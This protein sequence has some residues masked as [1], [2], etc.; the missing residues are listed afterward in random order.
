LSYTSHVFVFQQPF[1]RTR[2][3][4]RPTD[5]RPRNVF[6]F[7]I[8]PGRNQKRRFN[9]LQNFFPFRENTVT[10]LVRTAIY[11]C[12]SIWSSFAILERICFLFVSFCVGLWEKLRFCVGCSFQ[13]ILALFSCME[14]VCTKRLLSSGMWRR[15]VW[16][17]THVSEEPAS[18]VLNVEASLYSPRRLCWYPDYTALHHRRLRS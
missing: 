9:S 16:Q 8:D 10:V 12:H 14:A 11:N 2:W 6:F 15:V 4:T 7:C 13:S 5:R 17:L 3:Y 1:C 18:S